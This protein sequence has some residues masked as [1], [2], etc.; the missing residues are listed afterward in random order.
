LP[1][2]VLIFRTGQLGDT[3]VSMPAIHAIRRHHPGC[4]VVLLTDRHP[5]SGFVSSWDVLGESGWIDEVEFY[6]PGTGI[7][8][9]WRNAA[10]L[11]ARLRGRSVTH[12][13]LLTSGRT[14]WQRWRDRLFV[15]AVIGAR[16]CHDASGPPV[17][18]KAADGSLVRLEPEW[19]RLRDAIPLDGGDGFAL[20]ISAAAGR[21]AEI[22]L[23]AIGSTGGALL[24]AFGPGSKMPAKVWPAERYQEVGRRLLAARDNVRLVVLGGP[25]DVAVGN[26]LCAAWGPRSHNLA[27]RVSVMAGAAVLRHCSVYVGNDTGTMHLAALAGVPCVALFSARDHPGKWEPYGEGHAVLR[28]EV[29]CAGCMLEVCSEHGNKCL[30]LITVEEVLD[31]VEFVLR[32]KGGER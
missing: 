14:S 18:R 20:P 29:D 25:E 30:N 26:S 7:L 13:Y 5:G 24:V 3:L 31:A 27:G 28:R 4:T 1:Q 11:S 16:H 32:P 22:A 10:Q 21:E 17:S 2:T 15:R 19:R 8:G 23:A 6:V 12:A 9:M